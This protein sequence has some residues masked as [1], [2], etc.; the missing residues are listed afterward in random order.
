MYEYSPCADALY[1]M[2]CYIFRGDVRLAL[3]ILMKFSSPGQFAP[4]QSETT[5]VGFHHSQAGQRL[6]VEVSDDTPSQGLQRAV[7]RI[8][9]H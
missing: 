6:D 7:A 9:Y 5:S 4:G 3:Q 1:G 8:S 2:A